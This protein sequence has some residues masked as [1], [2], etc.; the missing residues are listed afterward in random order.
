[1]KSILSVAD[2]FWPKVDRSGDAECW[3][4][5]GGL[6]TTG[7]GRFSS[8]GLAHWSVHTG[9]HRVAWALV[10]DGV[11]PDGCVCHTCDNPVCC[12]PGHLFLGS[13]R[14]NAMD[15][16]A[17]GRGARGSRSPFAKLSD[18]TVA[19]M[20]QKRFEGRS[21]ASLATEYGVSKSTAERT[22][23]GKLWSHAAGPLSSKGVRLG[24]HP[25]QAEHGAST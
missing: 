20:R 9:A 14:D 8:K 13:H 6:Y 15:R 23:H 17:K 21:Y 24:S 3:P 25:A 16:A 19:E 10:N 5:K 1:M 18:S 2:R 4:W 22:C 12:N 7:Y 11:R